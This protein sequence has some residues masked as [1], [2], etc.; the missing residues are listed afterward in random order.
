MG[1]LRFRKFKLFFFKLAHLLSQGAVT[2]TKVSHLRTCP[3][4]HYTTLLYLYYVLYVKV[5]WA[6]TRLPRDNSRLSRK[7][8]EFLLSEVQFVSRTGKEVLWPRPKV[9]VGILE[10]LKPLANWYLW[11]EQVGS[12]QIHS[13]YLVWDFQV[14]PGIFVNSLIGWFFSDFSSSHRH[15]TASPPTAFP[16]VRE[17]YH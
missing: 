8:A 14:P 4:N 5:Y 3:L 2:Q 9:P 11:K 6:P 16:R 10:L 17:E 12:Q 1:K 15:P 13:R 7:V